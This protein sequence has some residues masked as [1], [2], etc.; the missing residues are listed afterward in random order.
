MLTLL[1]KELDLQSFL[2]LTQTSRVV[3]SLLMKPIILDAVARAQLWTRPGRGPASKNE[4]DWWESQMK[5]LEEQDPEEAGPG[6][7]WH[8]LMRCHSNPSM[9]N[10]RRIWGCV[11]QI[12]RCI[13][14]FESKRDGSSSTI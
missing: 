10:R 3:R 14:E 7:D 13:L 9:K 11:Q 2:A 1:A 12:E 6:F 5:K 4:R 8:Y